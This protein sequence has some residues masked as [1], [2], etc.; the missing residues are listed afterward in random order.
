VVQ[1]GL[2][3]SKIEGYGYRVQAQVRESGFRI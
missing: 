2:N 3:R 1:K